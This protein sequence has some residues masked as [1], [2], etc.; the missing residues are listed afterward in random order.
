[1]FIQQPISSHL[2]ATIKKVIPK[3][4]GS[5]SDLVASAPVATNT[6]G[7]TEVWI[8]GKPEC[9]ITGAFPLKYAREDISNTFRGIFPDIPNECQSS[10]ESVVQELNTRYGVTYD[11]AEFELT[12]HVNSLML[13]AKP[14]SYLYVGKIGI[15]TL[16]NLAEFG[17]VELPD[18]INQVQRLAHHYSYPLS[19]LGLTA[20]STVLAGESKGLTT[21]ARALEMETLDPWKVNKKAG[22]Y[23]LYGAKVIS[24]GTH[25]YSGRTE[26]LLLVVEVNPDYCTNFTGQLIL[27][28]SLPVADE[29]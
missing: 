28:Y 3:F 14:G 5:E 7:G 25:T 6:R 15:R 2:L 13:E 12:K 22:P 27:F 4:A 29:E 18:D 9:G 26:D 11:A 23:N 16:F 17:V 21:V 1:M 20:L 8:K 19:F 10:V 24:N